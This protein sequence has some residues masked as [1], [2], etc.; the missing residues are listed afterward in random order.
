MRD[1]PKV[2][3]TKDDLYHCLV[4][5][6]DGTL[7]YDDFKNAIKQIENSA[8]IHCPILEMDETKTIISVRYCVEALTDVKI[9]NTT[10]CKITNVEHLKDE[11][12]DTYSTS[13]VTI[14]KA[15]TNDD[16]ALLITSPINNLDLLGITS[17]ELTNIKG[18]LKNYE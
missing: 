6:Q 15:L 18:V 11:E 3:A 2:I 5:V 16:N 12:D 1:F 9:G 17:T 4:L 13:V 8:Y 7:K 10:S 14:S